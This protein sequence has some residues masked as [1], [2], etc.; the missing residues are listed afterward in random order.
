MSQSMLKLL[1]DALRKNQLDMMQYPL[2]SP[3]RWILIQDNREIEKA[4]TFADV[5]AR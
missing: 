4:L 3:E 1:W 2:N 5:T